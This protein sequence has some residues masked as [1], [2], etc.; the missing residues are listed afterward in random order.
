MGNIIGIRRED[1]SRWEKRVPL[2]PQHIRALKEKHS[3]EFML[4]P[5]KIRAFP[6][7]DYHQ[8]GAKIQEDLSPCPIILA[9]KET[10]K[11]F[12]EYGKTYIFFAHVIKGQS[13]NMPML[14]RILEFKCQLID[15]E[16]ITDKK[17]RRF[18]FF[19]KY[20]GLA[21][22]VDSLWA[23]GE[24]LKWE[25]ISN[26]FSEI[27]PTH[28][29]KNLEEVKEEIGK[30]GKTISEDGLDPQLL[31]FVCGIAGY[32]NVSKGVQEILDLL[33]VKKVTPKELPSLPK[34]PNAIYKVVFKEEDMVEPISNH[35]F[36]LQ[37]Y[38]NNP[39][40][41]RS[42]FTKYIPY[43]T[44]LMNCIYWDDRYPRLVTKDY[45]KELYDEKN[46]PRL[47]VIGDISCDI[48]GA[49]ECTLHP[50]NP[51]NSLFV[52][53]PFTQEAIDGY[54]VKGPVIMAIDNLPCELPFEASTYFS[55]VLKP[56]IPEIAGADFSVPFEKCRLP[57]KIKKAVIVYKGELTPDY[58][59][60]EEYL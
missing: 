1:K 45:L 60:I 6:D 32:G 40:R 51:D 47:R 11:G 33:P 31:P 48:E 46:L 44:L 28:Y 24:R 2:T 15:Y 7:E 17:G 50:T 5:S 25:G 55:G 29:Y 16:K 53:D 43:L 4:Q 8:A 38:Y 39:E 34:N 18:L 12:F 13:H 21:G 57:E 20:A 41:Y 37:D 58:K 10:P 22:I 30:L 26:P 54:K 36:D 27:S 35:K 49:I 14:R 23:L 42:K 3:I 59:Y 19:G 9:I 56:F 52:Y